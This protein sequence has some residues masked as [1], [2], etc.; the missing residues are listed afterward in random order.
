MANI[1]A[2]PTPPKRRGRPPKQAAPT[3]PSCF[4]HMD[5][6]A[7]KAIDRA[8]KLMEESA[9]YRTEAMNHPNTIRTYLKFKL[10]PLEH[11]ELHAIWLD[12]RNHIIAFE[13]LASGSLTQA[14]VYPREVVKAALRH[15]AAGLVLAHNH[16]SGALEPSRA[17]VMLNE[18]LLAV[19]ALIDVKIIDHFIVAG[20]SDP[21][22]FKERGIF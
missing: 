2:A 17:D 21:L 4:H 9:V 18:S 20:N 3:I 15:N 19:L 7:R 14:N 10:A 13:R 16:P 1:K 6:R 22:S 11:E 12:V 5:D 8:A